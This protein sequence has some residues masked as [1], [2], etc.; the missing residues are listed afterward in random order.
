[1]PIDK[2]NIPSHYPDVMHYA[3]KD[4][5][6]CVGHYVKCRKDFVTEGEANTY[7]RKFRAFRKSL[8]M[9]PLYDPPSTKKLKAGVDLRLRKVYAATH[10]EVHCGWFAE[11]RFVLK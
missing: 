6:E 11:L 9:Y 8:E 4:A 3:V 2:P 1:M 7:M 10:W 5:A